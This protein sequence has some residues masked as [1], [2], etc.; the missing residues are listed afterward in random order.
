MTPDIPA[1]VAAIMVASAV[2]I[3]VVVWGI[4][5][6]AARRAGLARDAQRRVQVGAGAF[7]GA[8]LGAVFLLAPASS[9]PAG[10]PFRI[11]PLIPLSLVASVAFVLASLWRSPSLRR[12]FASVPVAALNAAQS[13]R[14]IGIVFVVLYTRGQLP[15]H[16]ALPAG[17]GDVAV[18]LTAPFV[19]LALARGL[20]GAP[21][22]AVAW[23]LVGLLDLAVAVGMGTGLL[24]PLLVPGLG[25]RVPPAA[26][27]GVLPMLLVPAFAVP[28]SVL[29]HVFALRGLMRRPRVTPELVPGVAR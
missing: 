3:A 26:A 7:L 23:N 18:G 4:L 24:A 12:T 8:W 2:V 9:P 22:L 16:F 17:W 14:V 10:D 6:S 25:P 1:Y 19:A 27:M 20:R 28:M 13:W 5:A 21:A 11:T 29:M 15:A